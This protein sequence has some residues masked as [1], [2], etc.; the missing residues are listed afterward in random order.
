LS[1]AAIGDA[2]AR[3]R[4]NL[5]L[6]KVLLLNE[7]REEKEARAGTEE[8]FAKWQWMKQQRTFLG[9][10]ANFEQMLEWQKGLHTWYGAAWV[11][12][13]EKQQQDIKTWFLLRKHRSPAQQDEWD[14]LMADWSAKVYSQWQQ[15]LKEQEDTWN[16]SLEFQQSLPEPEQTSRWASVSPNWMPLQFQHH[17]NHQ[18]DLEEQ[19]T[20]HKLQQQTQQQPQ[21]QQPQQHQFQQPQQPQQHQ[22]QQPQQQGDAMD[23]G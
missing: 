22:F 17:Q 11:A 15:L 6:A 20:E 16:N 8:E 19:F 10:K 18:R 5:D 4:G 14:K 21:F 1:S 12:Q 13:R 23:V 2:L 9:Q 3:T 7:D